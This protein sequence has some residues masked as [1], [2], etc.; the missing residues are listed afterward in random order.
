VKWYNLGQAHISHSGAIWDRYP[1][2]IKIFFDEI[3]LKL[4]ERACKE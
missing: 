2:T 1:S 3:R 4:G